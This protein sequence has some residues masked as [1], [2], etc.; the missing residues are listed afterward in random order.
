MQVEAGLMLRPVA[1][2]PVYASDIVQAGDQLLKNMQSRA[3][4]LLLT[5]KMEGDLTMGSSSHK[6]KKGSAPSEAICGTQSYHLYEA[7]SGDA[8]P[9]GA[10]TCQAPHG[11]SKI[12]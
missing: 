12:L 2:K 10:K 8:T 11:Y 1:M 5:D 9:E 6:D 3:S 7:D 4:N